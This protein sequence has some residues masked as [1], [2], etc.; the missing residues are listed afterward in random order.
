MATKKPRKPNPKQAE[1]PRP[2]PD[3]CVTRMPP[4][5][6]QESDRPPETWPGKPPRPGEKLP[7]LAEYL[8]MAEDDSAVLDFI[9]RRMVVYPDLEKEALRQHRIE[10]IKERLRRGKVPADPPVP[11][12]DPS[13]VV[14]P[15]PPKQRGAPRKYT[16]EHAV[17]AKELRQQGK[18]LRQIAQ[19]I[20][21]RKTVTE[22]EIGS[23]WALINRPRK[24]DS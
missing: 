8:G 20:L 22:G 17:R 15:D 4:D 12:A 24:S 5:T 2:D 6:P 7:S 3:R 9:E 16:S 11:A 21:N 19:V 23:M 13:P 18:T 14:E 1:V 10:E